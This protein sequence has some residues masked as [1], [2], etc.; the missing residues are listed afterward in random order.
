MNHKSRYCFKRKDHSIID[1]LYRQ[2]HILYRNSPLYLKTSRTDKLTPLISQKQAGLL[3]KFEELSRPEGELFKL[4]DSKTLY[5]YFVKNPPEKGQPNKP[6]IMRTDLREM[7][8][9]SLQEDYI[10]WAKKLVEVKSSDDEVYDLYFQDGSVE[11][12][13]DLV[14]GADGAFSKV[15]LLVSSEPAH[16]CGITY[17]QVETPVSEVRKDVSDLIEDGAVLTSR[18]HK[19]IW[20]QRLS[21]P[22]N[23]FAALMCKSSSLINIFLCGRYMRASRK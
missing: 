17:I 10:K 18:D 23:I 9:D 12:G 15:R 3:P 14:V 20:G 4:V 7:L 21:S 8:L 19:A 1:V 11:K 16:Y 2:S 13:F 22:G 6:E 5:P